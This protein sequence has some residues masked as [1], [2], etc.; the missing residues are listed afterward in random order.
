[1]VQL[2]ARPKNV[3]PSKDAP[4]YIPP[5]DKTCMDEVKEVIHMPKFDDNKVNNGD[6]YKSIQIEHEITR[7]LGAYVAGVAKLYR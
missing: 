4:K 5:P 3:K 2:H 7:D 6:D 1:M